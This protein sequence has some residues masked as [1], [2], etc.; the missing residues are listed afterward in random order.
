MN[1]TAALTLYPNITATTKPIL[2]TI[3]GSLGNQIATLEVSM[4][5]RDSEAYV[6]P[7]G[8]EQADFFKLISMI[9]MNNLPKAV[10]LATQNNYTLNYYV[11]RGD[12]YAV[13]YLLNEEKPVRKGWGLYA[14]RLDSK[15]NIIIEAP[16]PIYDKRTPSVALAIYRA[17]DAR[18]LMIAGAHRNANR[19]KSADVAH[20]KESI[21]QSIHIALTQEI[22][23]KSGDIIILQIHGFHGSKH[24]GYPQVVFGLGEKPLPQEITIAEKI[25]DALSKQGISAD[26]C[27]GL[28]GNLLELCAK[29]NVQG[30]VTKEGTFIHIELDENIRDHDEAFI[31]ALKEVF[32]N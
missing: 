13:S 6:I 29:T 18:A 28:E 16:H 1:S 5:R 20:A 8:L 23:A 2:E 30:S 14:F 4:P 32:G 17:L 10:D 19:D 25:K 12:D 15:S 11:D 22:E 9:M 21:F 7:T 27:T 26:V 31:A 24:K 3:E